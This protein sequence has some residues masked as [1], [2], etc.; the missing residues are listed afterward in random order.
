MLPC[1]PYL[2]LITLMGEC[3]LHAQKSQ[4]KSDAQG[5]VLGNSALIPSGLCGGIDYYYYCLGRP[6]LAPIQAQES[7]PSILTWGW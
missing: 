1:A 5:Y 7:L 2:E 6:G 4:D 3:V